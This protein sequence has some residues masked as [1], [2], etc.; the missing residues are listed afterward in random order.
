MV[1]RDR[2]DS[3]GSS[4]FASATFKG[5]RLTCAACVHQ[6]RLMVKPQGCRPKDTA[7]AKPAV[8]QK[9]PKMSAFRQMSKD[10]ERA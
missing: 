2:C 10:G 4:S 7:P 8:H 5:G 6:Q 3:C 9:W 1:N